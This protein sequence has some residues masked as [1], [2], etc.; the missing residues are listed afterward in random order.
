M[1]SSETSGAGYGNSDFCAS[2]NPLTGPTQRARAY[3][4]HNEPLDT[5]LYGRDQLGCNC[6]SS[7]EPTF[8]ENIMPRAYKS[9]LA[10]FQLVND[11]PGYHE[12]EVAPQADDSNRYVTWQ[13]GVEEEVCPESPR[14]A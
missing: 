5:P 7:G 6:F 14:A 11:V 1:R 9:M 10:Y 8:T 13:D 2:L 4:T 3:L 12:T